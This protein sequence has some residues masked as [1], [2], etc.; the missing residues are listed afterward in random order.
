M[1]ESIFDLMGQGTIDKELLDHIEH[2][3]D[4]MDSNRDGVV[5]LE[6]FI[7]Y[8]G[9]SEEVRKSLLVLS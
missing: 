3:F 4:N 1:S 5:T 2:V 8:C 9:R 7:E 6:E